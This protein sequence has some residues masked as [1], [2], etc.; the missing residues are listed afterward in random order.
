MPSSKLSNGAIAGISIAASVAFLALIALVVF[1]GRRRRRANRRKQSLIVNPRL[2]SLRRFSFIARS[3]RSPSNR[4]IHSP[5]GE[6]DPHFSPKAL[7]GSEGG[8]LDIRAHKDGEDEIDDLEAAGG[9]HEI[10]HPS[11]NSD[12][13]FSIDLPELPSRGYSHLRTSSGQ[14]S[15]PI[16]PVPA[17][18]PVPVTT[19]RFSVRP[20]KPMGPRSMNP[21]SPTIM[22]QRET[23]RGI[24]LAEMYRAAM[25][26]DHADANAEPSSSVVQASAVGLRQS[27][28]PEEFSPLR[29]N[30]EDEPYETAL[31][32][33]EG[34]YASAGVISLPQSLRL[35][36][37]FESSN[38]SSPLIPLHVAVTHSTPVTPITPITPVTPVA[39][40]HGFRH[41]HHLSF[42]D[43]DSSGSASLKSGGKST[44]QSRSNSTRSSSKSRYDPSTTTDYG[45]LLPDRR[46]SLG[47]SMAMAGPSS[48]RPSLSP[49]ISLQ[50]VSLPAQSSPHEPASVIPEDAS[51]QIDPDNNGQPMDFLPSPT[52]SIP[53]TVS[54]IHFRHSSYS[55][56]SFPTDS[57]RTSVNRFSG[58][59]RHPP[60][61]GT[62]AAPPPEP[63]PFIVQKLLGMAPSGAGPATPYSSPTTP[64]QGSSW[65]PS[66]P[67]R[68]SVSRSHPFSLAPPSFQMRPK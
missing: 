12:G 31:Q 1:C 3:I 11:Q 64:G 18:A 44:T 46:I 10:R 6:K 52:E 2:S 41:D 58:I 63:K 21:T 25:G 8:V 19:S 30:F 53:H 54:D 22:H 9:I 34:R 4:S 40:Q 61:P 42:L 49:N 33:R 7:E 43:L 20:S 55:T 17:S 5:P 50:P 16:S 45:S 26:D 29:V 15:I 35:A 28:Q 57:R 23:S 51:Q 13:S 47:L 39:Q 56:S 36:L 14:Q 66:T 38:P 32:R 67:G 68:G 62:S 27:Q 48:S 60:L 37:S 59:Q 65:P 24:L